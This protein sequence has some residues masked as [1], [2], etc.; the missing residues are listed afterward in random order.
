MKKPFQVDDRV[1][2]YSH[3]GRE[4]GRIVD[5]R[6]D[7]M[8]RVLVQDDTISAWVHWK[9]LRRLVKKERQTIRLH[10]FADGKFDRVCTSPTFNACG[11]HF[12]RLFIEVRRKKG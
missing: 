11:P 7:G 4:I 3:K 2:V 12:C 5:V 9:Q 10:F 1:A 6:P 8:I